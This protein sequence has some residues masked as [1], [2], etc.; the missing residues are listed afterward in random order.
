MW[1][2]Y[3]TASSLFNSITVDEHWLLIGIKGVNPLS[4]NLRSEVEPKHDFLGVK[5]S[6]IW[7]KGGM[8]IFLRSKVTKVVFGNGIKLSNSKMALNEGISR[9]FLCTVLLIYVKLG[10]VNGNHNGANNTPFVW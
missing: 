4:Y 7:L 6:K 5:L 3:I 8:K 2:M 9:N 10:M 1:L